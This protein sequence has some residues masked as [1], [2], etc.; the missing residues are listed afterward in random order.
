[1]FQVEAAIQHFNINMDNVILVIFEVIDTDFIY[2][3]KEQNRYKFVLSFKNWTIK[4]VFFR[5]KKVQNFLN[6][7]FYLKTQN[8]SYTL[9]TSHYSSDAGLLF[10]S[11]VKPA[12][13][14]LMDEGT[15]S[16]SVH[17]KRQNKEWKRFNYLIKSI[18]YFQRIHLP[19]KVTYFTQYGIKPNN[20]DVIENYSV[21]KQKNPLSVL[22][23]NEAIFIGSSAVE[24][25]LMKVEHYIYFLKK[26]FTDIKIKKFYYFPHRKE[27]QKKLS[28][29]RDIGFVIEKHEEPFEKRF[30]RLI[31]CPHLFCSLFLSGVLDNISKNNEVVPELRIYKFDSKLFLTNGEEQVY[32]NI[33]NEMLSNKRLKF[34]ELPTAF[35]N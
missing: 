10:L 24:V 34:I 35:M 13:Y 3:I 30:G 15:A 26:I 17:Y 9:F 20:H 29:I 31:E 27:S 23:D 21:Q 28:L 11:I 4:D 7:C 1:M 18:L 2:K 22:I 16:F 19:Y 12:Y 8:I 33:Y 25:G 5:Y 32:E 14:Y 6:F